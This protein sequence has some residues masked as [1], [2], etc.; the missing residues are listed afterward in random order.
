MDPVGNLLTIF[1]IKY[2]LKK[3]TNIIG[4]YNP[5][6]RIIGLVSHTTYVVCINFY[7][8]KWR[9]IQYKADSEWQI[10]WETFHG[11]IFVCSQIFCQKSAEMKSP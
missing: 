11:N 6:I 2:L 10:F 4:H 3:N 8:H 1:L 9:D 5:S 7:T